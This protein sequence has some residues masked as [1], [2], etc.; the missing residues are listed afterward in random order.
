MSRHP[1]FGCFSLNESFVAFEVWC[2]VQSGFA[3]VGDLYVNA[4][5]FVY[6]L[7]FNLDRWLEFPVALNFNEEAFVFIPA[8]KDVQF[9]F[10]TC[11]CKLRFPR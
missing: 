8:R 1:T 9:E 4:A 5:V 3:V 7:E 2:S 6:V 10:F 11:E